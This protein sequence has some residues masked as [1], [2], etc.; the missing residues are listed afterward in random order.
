MFVRLK[1]RA[2]GRWALLGFI[3]YIE[4]SDE[5]FVKGNGISGMRNFW[6]F[7]DFMVLRSHVRFFGLSGF[8]VRVRKDF[9]IWDFE[10]EI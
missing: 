7:L 5:V 4:M 3:S 1:P 2:D 6:I 8:G 10:W 9:L